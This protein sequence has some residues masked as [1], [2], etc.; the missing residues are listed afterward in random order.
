MSS[1]PGRKTYSRRSDIPPDV[2]A[3]LNS[4]ELA[5][6]T[7]A[8]GLALDFALLL[9]AAVPTLPAEAVETVR[10]SAAL[11]IT[12]RMELVADL[13]LAHL[14]PTALE[15][16]GSHPSDTVRGWVCYAIGRSPKSTLADRLKRIRPLA[17]DPHFGVREW[18]WIPLRPAIAADV[19]AAVEL[20]LPWA[21]DADVNV[22][23]Y[24]VEIT[25][26]RGV[27]TAHL[28]AMK[29]TPGLG[30]PL[31]E[32]NKGDSSKYVQ[33]SVAN[34]LN[35]AGKSQPEW[36][37]GVVARWRKESAAP[38]TVRICTRALRSLN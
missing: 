15:K 24:A 2:L 16:L 4:G 36:V 30:L 26:P 10:A 14:K 6:A 17:A 34:W 27:W 7:L 11:G 37:R 13:L 20:L 35:D 32:A 1:V 31:L 9:A 18:A 5:T 22:R 23:R 8:E 12:K 33:D 25:R 29:R 38:A 28:D 21:T 3:A 19:P